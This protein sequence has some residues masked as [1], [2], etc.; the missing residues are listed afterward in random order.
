M[1]DALSDLR[2]ISRMGYR[3]PWA[4]ATKNITDSLLAYGNSKLQRDALI[5]SAEEK[6]KREE[7]RAEDK[8]YS[9]RL[10]LWNSID[11][12]DYGT[13]KVFIN[14]YGT[15]M[16]GDA[17]ISS[18]ISS[19]I[20]KGLEY[21]SL[22]ESN[23]D[24]YN[25][26][27]N[28][29][30]QRSTALSNN[31][32]ASAK[33][34]D[35]G[36]ERRYNTQINS[37]IKERKYEFEVNNI[38]SLIESER[39]SSLEGWEADKFIKMVQSGNLTGAEQGLA[40]NVKLKT[41]RID[42][43]K[44]YYESAIE[45]LEVLKDE[46]EDTMNPMSDSEYNEIRTSYTQKTLPFLPDKYASL[47]N[48]YSMEDIFAFAEGSMSLGGGGGS[49]IDTQDLKDYA[50]K[51]NITIQQAKNDILKLQGVLQGGGDGQGGLQLNPDLNM[52]SEESVM[53][54][55]SNASNVVLI[56]PV[57]KKKIKV[58][59]QNA[60]SLIQRGY[61][62]SED[63]KD[64]KSSYINIRVS[65]DPT[66]DIT[67]E[68]AGIGDELTY[69]SS[70]SDGV[71]TKKMITTGSKVIEKSTGKVL[72]VEVRE[73]KKPKIKSSF[74]GGAG[75]MQRGSVSKYDKYIYYVGGKKVKSYKEFINK[76]G[77]PIY[78]GGESVS[79][80][81]TQQRL[82]AFNVQEILK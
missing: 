25:D 81:S 60:T 11:K 33:R 76:Y 48:R 44:K 18:S 51:N 36:A 32:A 56:N 7:I 73:N 23:T 45:K 29:F 2:Y 58:T 37:L 35:F 52:Q 69:I 42:V 34:G 61:S 27:N 30:I 3:D 55:I 47:S 49:R 59:G 4:E 38:T 66:S 15:E 64:K 74:V 17:D 65:P 43:G 26:K 39:G 16:F 71:S 46:R 53:N 13:K 40:R 62:L 67:G 12:N 28:S 6:T 78:V 1:S 31:A 68:F 20:D 79:S 63:I 9:R 24:V 80:D 5:K 77:I 50:K 8:E 82:S 21:Q 41:D 70:S 14:K 54:N 75:V 19:N 22:I 10:A 72:K 57:T